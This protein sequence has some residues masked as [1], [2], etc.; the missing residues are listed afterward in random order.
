MQIKEIMTERP[1]RVSSTDTVL[2]AIRIMNHHQIRHLP[3]VRGTQLVGIISE[4]DIRTI[5]GTVSEVEQDR[6]W[7]DREKLCYVVEAVMTTDVHTLSPDDSVSTA[8]TLFVARRIGALPVA[9]DDG[10]LVG[11]V[12]YIDLLNHIVSP[13][14]GV[15][16]DAVPVEEAPSD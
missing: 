8:I 1:I 13:M 14:S 2:G 4:R 3:V 15:E 9:T 6:L 11:I 12:S 16:G 10:T 7:I 5:I